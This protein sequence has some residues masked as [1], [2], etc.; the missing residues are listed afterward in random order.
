MNKADR[1][2]D[3]LVQKFDKNIYGTTKGR[4]RHELL[5]HGLTQHA[6]PGNTMRILDA[7]GG[8]GEMTY[9]L[10]QLG[11]EV[12]L[13]DLSHDSLVVAK[14][15]CAEFSD[16]NYECG[17]IA[18]LTNTQQY[19]LVLCHAV[20]EWVADPEQLLVDLIAKVKSG[21]CVSISFFNLDAQLF[22][23]MVYGNFHFVMSGMKK[24]N[25]VRLTPHSPVAP[26]QVLQWI[27][28]LPANIMYKAGIRCFHDYLREKSLAE[29][30]YS[31]LLA[32]EKQYCTVEP[33]LWLG[34]YF[35]VIFKKQ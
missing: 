5:L 16:V 12:T 31:E 27:D 25:Q 17:P 1:N 28:Q 15:K 11:H 32:L 6:L 19:D 7:G 23:N 18:S 22:G 4:L 21:G 13:N 35:H 24:R 2:F 20:M 30:K 9:S 10:A 14:H 8:T 33:Y 34:K 29:Q 3:D 26:K